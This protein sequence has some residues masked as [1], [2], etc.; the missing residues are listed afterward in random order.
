MSWAKELWNSAVGAA[1][2]HSSYPMLIRLLVTR[3]TFA[4]LNCCATDEA[5][6]AGA[7]DPAEPTAKW[8]I[9]AGAVAVDAGAVATDA[10]TV[11]ADAGAVATDVG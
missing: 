7:W 4:V 9:S 10:G 6:E 1:R 11:A 2:C 8:S 3:V 5:E